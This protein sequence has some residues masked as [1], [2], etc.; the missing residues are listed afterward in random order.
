MRK[1][2][3]ILL[4]TACWLAIGIFASASVAMHLV[5][6][7]AIRSDAVIW[8]GNTVTDPLSSL[9]SAGTPMGVAAVVPLG[10]LWKRGLAAGWPVV[11]ASLV[12]VGFTASLL[13]GGI[14]FFQA[15]LPG[16]HLSEVVWWMRPFGGLFGV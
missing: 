3:L 11:P 2:S 4:K 10:V 15:A 7:R 16:Y 9:L 8:C 12:V 6:A 5:L 1:P 14:R 13:V